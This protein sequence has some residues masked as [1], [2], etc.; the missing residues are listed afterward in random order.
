MRIDLRLEPRPA[1]PA[2]EAQDAPL[3]APRRPRRV[4]C[5]VGTRP[6]VIKMAPVIRALRAAPGLAVSVLSSGQHGDLLAPLLEWF[7]LSIDADLQVMTQNQSLAELTARLM[8][9]FAGRFAATRPELVLAQGDTTTVLCAALT[10]FYLDIPFGH[11]EA[12]LRT[13]QPRSPFPEEFNRVAVG[14]LARLHFCPTA[15]AR[16][17]LLAERVGESAAQLTGNTVIDALRFTTDKLEKHATRAFDHDILLTAHRRENFGAPLGEIFRALLELC[18]RFPALKVLYPV[19]PNPNVRAV[20]HRILGGHPQIA[21]V[22]PLDY[23][24]LVAAMRAAKLI[25]TDSGGIQEEAPA[26]ARPV[27][28]LRAVTERPEAVEIGAAKLVGSSRSAIV[29]EASRLLLDPEHY[30]R[31]APGRS[32]YGD[33]RAAQRIRD[34]VCRYLRADMALAV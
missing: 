29:G 27:L 2:P 20:A 22:E 26:L 25:L 23:P 3:H 21:L 11:V 8:Q 1:P 17:N 12:G 33:G 24:E 13:F 19:H 9:G 15:R 5:I 30:A 18:R 6:E 34:S 4:V 31:M 16:D 28:V 14:R 10:C 7:E 32:P